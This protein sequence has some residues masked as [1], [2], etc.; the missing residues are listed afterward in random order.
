MSEELQQLRNKLEREQ[1]AR[2]QAEQLLEQKSLELYQ[3]NLELSN[4]ADAL[5]KS[6]A[7]LEQFA[8][9]VSHDLQAPLRNIMSFTKLLERELGEDLSE[10]SVEY[11]AFI[12]DG[13]RQMKALIEDILALSRVSNRGDPFE[14]CSLE[15]IVHEAISRH[16]S[17]IRENSASVEVGSLPQVNADRAQLVQ[18][19][20]NL[21]GNAIKFRAAERQPTIHISATDEEGRVTVRVQDNGRGIAEEHRGEIFGVF[22]RLQSQ[23]QI[24]GSG[25][26]LSI[27][28]KIIE[29]HSGEIHVES[30]VG[31]GSTFVFTLPPAVT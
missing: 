10:S 19:L 30:I 16:E 31:E 12:A 8:Y 13:V 26:G 20:Q 22:K 24:E 23:E 25:I 17:D 6:N 5:A 14:N 11:M 18:L 21:I 3:R 29:R 27:C 1:K 28:K 9:V 4:K 15:D 2:A 7:D